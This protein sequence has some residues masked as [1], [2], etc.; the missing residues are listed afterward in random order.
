MSHGRRAWRLLLALAGALAVL[1]LLGLAVAE[2]RPGGGHT[3]SGGGG[4]GGGGGG[5]GGDGLINLLLYLII[6]YPQIGIPVLVIVVVGYLVAQRSKKDLTDWDTGPP[7]YRGPPPDLERIRGFDPEFSIVRFEDF[8]YRLYAAAHGDRADPAKLEGLTPY[9]APDVRSALAAR[10]PVGAPIANVVI[11]AMRVTELQ[12]PP[13]AT[14]ED[15]QPY[16]IS[17]ELEFEANMTATT[18]RGPRTYFVVER[19]QLG[20]A[21]DVVSKPLETAERFPCP[22]CGAPFSAADN[23]QCEYCGQVVDNGRFD[24]LVTSVRMLHSADRLDLISGTVQE[25]GTDLPTVVHHDVDRNWAELV[26]SDPA[27]TQESIGA[28]LQLIY[29]EL[30]KAWTAL[31]LT[32]IRPFVSDGMFDYLQYWIDAYRQQGLRNVLEEMRMFHWTHARITRDKYFDAI[33][34]RVWGTGKDYTVV[35]ESGKVVSGSKHRERRYTEYWTLIR[36]AQARGAARADKFCPSCGAELKISMAGV[37][38]YC[39]THVTSGEFDW[40]LSKIEQDDSY[41]G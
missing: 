32:P 8:V 2:A 26:A 10:E 18:E 41:R 5:G 15:G 27:I 34:V 11:G 36:S 4:H 40:V 13:A 25:R 35:A 3:Y 19:W 39:G 17:L 1:L 6:Y 24:W 23:Q 29:D 16:W 7:V 31:D 22:N 38:D 14:T 33:T 20:R 30:N 21:A 28:R 12:L 37:C 9:L